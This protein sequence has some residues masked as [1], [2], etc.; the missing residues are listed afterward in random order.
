MFSSR[1]QMRPW[2]PRHPASCPSTYTLFLCFL[3]L[4][5]SVFLCDFKMPERKISSDHS[6]IQRSFLSYYL[7]KDSVLG[8]VCS[9]A[10]ACR[11]RSGYLSRYR[12]P[13]IQELGPSLKSSCFL[14][15]SVGW[16][17]RGGI[18]FMGLERKRPRRDPRA[19]LSP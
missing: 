18:G 3:P 11:R 2:V 5:F 12:F 14:E 6:F 16:A 1:T 19:L 10:T 9:G 8:E 15:P 7:V 4:P 17:P 13:K